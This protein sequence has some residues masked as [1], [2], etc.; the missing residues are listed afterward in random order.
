MPTL[1]GIEHC[2]SSNEAFDL[3]EL[4]RRV[5]IVGGGY[6]AVEFAGIFR[7]LGAEV[8]ISY[9]RDQVLR[10]FDHDVRATLQAELR[11]KGMHLDMPTV[12][13]SVEKCAD[14]SLI[15]TLRNANDTKRL[16]C[17]AVMFATG[18]A[19]NTASLGLRELGV[20]LDNEGGI[21][22]DEYSRSSVENIFAVG[23]VT[24]RYALTPVAIREG[25][26]FALTMFGNTPTPIDHETIPT[27]VFSQPPIGT[28]GLTEEAALK[29]HGSVDVYKTDFKALKHT[30]SGRDERTMMKLVVEPETG[31]VLGAHMV[32]ADAPEIIQ[33]V[34]IAVKAGLTKAQFDATC[35]IHPSAAEEF[36]TLKEKRTVTA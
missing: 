24:H 21:R 27:A 16:A 25:Q 33:G 19:P 8:T 7:G 5:L 4:P 6:I 20:K 35:A 9:R 26:A 32:G 28:V 30:L 31:R 3:P 12:V 13:E 22:V 1:P 14:G 36:V 15:A 2:I 10:G 17:D 29:R 23:D 18:R 34:A 11:K